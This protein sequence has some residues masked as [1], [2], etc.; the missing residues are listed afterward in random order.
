MSAF[1]AIFAVPDKLKMSHEL[2]DV[3]SWKSGDVL[4]LRVL[5]AEGALAS[6][7][8]AAQ[9]AAAWQDA[10]AAQGVKDA[11]VA[12]ATPA[13]IMIEGVPK[14]AVGGAIHDTIAA[15]PET[16]WIEPKID[17]EVSN[18]DAAHLKLGGVSLAAGAPL[19][20]DVLPALWQAGIK[21][22]G[23]VVGVGDSGLDVDSCYFSDAGQALNQAQFARGSVRDLP[24]HRKIAQYFAASDG[25]DLPG[26]HGTHVAGSVAGYHTANN[27]QESFF[28]GVAYEAKVAVF[29]IGINS[30]PRAIFPPTRS[31][32]TCFRPPTTWARAF[33]PTRGAVP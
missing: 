5:L 19:T 1:D 17:F 29:D 33:T 9:L 32:E 31:A 16:A 20:R 22:A 15:A 6:M 21:G 2:S 8:E 18:Y 4:D 10:L 3:G 26:G 7:E 14:S 25:E 28:N 11:A 27:D 30:N 23:Q 24:N 12:A 13:M